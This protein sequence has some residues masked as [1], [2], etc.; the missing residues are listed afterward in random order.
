ML[1]LDKKEPKTALKRFFGGVTGNDI[2]RLIVALYLVVLL[3]P[4]QFIMEIVPSGS[5]HGIG[6]GHFLEEDITESEDGIM[7]LPVSLEP[8]VSELESLSKY[9]L[10]FYDSHIV[11]SGEN[12]SG[13]AANFGLNQDTIISVNKIT[14][15]RL[16]QAGRVI[17]V[18]NQDGIFHTVRNGD[19][20]EALAERYSVDQETIKIANELF[21][22]NIVVGSDLFITGARLSREA[23]QEINGDLFIWPVNGAVTSSFGW[24]RNPFNRNQRQFHNGIDIRGST[25]TAVRAA[26]AGRVTAAGWDT[27]FGNYIIINHHSGYRTLYG[28]L[29]RIRTRTGAFVA[30]GERI[31]DV[32]NTGQSTGSHLHFS[33]FRNG[34]AI[35]PRPL[36]R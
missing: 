17:R 23:L 36:M 13:L 31:G 18:P 8:I 34:V 24:R 10:L 30:Q 27:V 26:M 32:G 22:D 5:E 3:K 1:S 16:L 7:L 25:G 21:S 28:H 33:V 20:L 4:G 9:R 12:I 6:G 19:T 11:Q 15:S 29:D 14:S 2:F 35:N